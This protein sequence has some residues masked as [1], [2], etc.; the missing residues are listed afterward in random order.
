MSQMPPDLQK[1]CGA[2]EIR[3]PDLLH[4]ISRQHVHHCA[5][6][7]VT[8]PARARQSACIRTGCGTFLLYFFGHLAV[9]ARC[10]SWVS[11]RHNAIPPVHR[12]V[13]VR[14]LPW[15]PPPWGEGL[16]APARPTSDPP[17]RPACPLVI[18][19]GRRRTSAA[20]PTGFSV[21]GRGAVPVV[22]S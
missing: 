20:A 14:R 9:G 16:L 5:S 8:V 3:T 10:H 2:M 21:D 22:A 1:L 17:T 7:Q 19:V 11:D 18:R 12:P 6:A 4:A 15:A 13:L